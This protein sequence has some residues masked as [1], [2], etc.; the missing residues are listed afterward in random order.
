MD[1]RDI[2]F[3]NIEGWNQLSEVAEKVFIRL[4]K[5]HNSCLGLD[6]KEQWEPIKVKEFRAYL[7]V[8]FV[9]GEWL[10]YYPNGTWG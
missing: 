4:Y 10:H 1:Y 2:K 6:Y 5:A 9:N 3:S 7:K 8:W